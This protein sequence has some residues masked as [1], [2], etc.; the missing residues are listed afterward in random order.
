MT[1]AGFEVEDHVTFASGEGEIT[2]TEDRE[3]LDVLLAARDSVG[4]R[5]R[6]VVS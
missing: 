6:Y 2:W 5:I 4:A 3:I 1:D